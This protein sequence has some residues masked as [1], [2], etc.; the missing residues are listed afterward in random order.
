MRSSSAVSSGFAFV[1]FAFLRVVVAF[2]I[3][4]AQLVAVFF[5]FIPLLQSPGPFFVIIEIIAPTLFRGKRL[6]VR[7][8]C[9]A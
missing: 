9:V 8:M 4:L 2:L 6:S 5:D 3:R 7:E 1:G